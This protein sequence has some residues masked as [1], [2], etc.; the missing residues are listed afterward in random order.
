VTVSFDAW[1]QGHVAPVRQEIEIVPAAPDPRAATVSSRL[2]GELT[3]PNKKGMLQ[4]LRFSPDGKRL[5]AGDGSAG[6]IQIWDVANKKPLTRIEAGK[7]TAERGGARG[8]GTFFALSPDWQK[9]YAKA[10][11]EIGVWNPQTGQ[12]IDTLW[13]ERQTSVRSLMLSSDGAALI[14]TAGRAGGLIWDYAGIVGVR[15]EP[16]L[17]DGLQLKGVLIFRRADHLPF[18]QRFEA[19][20]SHGAPIQLRFRSHDGRPRSLD[21]FGG[22]T[23]D[24]RGL[25]RLG[26][27]Q[28]CFG[29]HEIP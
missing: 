10:G 29:C 28:L 14:T 17:V 2:Q 4:G 1:K 12:Q 7:T 16:A 20:R 5:V 9:L 24:Q 26:L 23:G 13:D 3:L 15:G 27:C 18:E 8:G 19:I 25:P 22:G 6:V 21:L 11:A